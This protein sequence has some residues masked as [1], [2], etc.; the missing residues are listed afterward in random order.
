MRLFM[1]LFI[2]ALSFVGCAGSGGLDSSAYQVKMRSVDVGM[3]KHEFRAV[4]LEANA[5][6]PGG[7]SGQPLIPHIG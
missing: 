5:R 3:T 2:V 6:G 1:P 4:F 7:P